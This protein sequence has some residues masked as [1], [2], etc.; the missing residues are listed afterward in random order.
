MTM[1]DRMRRHKNILKWTLALVVLTFVLL[2][3]P[4]FLQNNPL[5][6]GA[7]PREVVAEVGGVQLKAGD[8]QQ[9]YLAQINAYRAD[10]KSV[11]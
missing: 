11:V 7:A 5:G 2:Y 6:A 3:V 8:F 1:L 9:R 4:D 10:R